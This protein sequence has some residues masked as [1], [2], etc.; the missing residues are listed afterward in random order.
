M[1]IH[2]KIEEIRNKPEQQRLKYV[3]GAVAISMFFVIAIWILSVKIS[4]QRTP[5]QSLGQSLPDIGKQLQDIKD[6]APSLGDINQLSSGVRDV[7]LPAD[8]SPTTDRS[9]QA[10]Q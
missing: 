4:L 1:N 9:T 7:Q 8:S 3:W 2:A 6:T 5:D 10:A